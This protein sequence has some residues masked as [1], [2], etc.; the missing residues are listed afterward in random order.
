MSRLSKWLKPLNTPEPSD[1]GIGLGGN[2]GDSR[3]RIFEALDALRAR[4]VIDVTAVSSIYRTAPWGPVVQDD[5]ANA[6]AIGT[7]K[8]MPLALLDAIKQIERDLGRVETVR[9]G[10]RVIDID[11]LYYGDGAYEDAR[12]VLPHR[13]LFQRAFVL[14]PLAEIAPD[15]IIG[16]RRIIDAA[17]AI[18]S[19]DVRLWGNG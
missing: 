8:L 14:H 6:C 9:W 5:F 13:D 3:V 16:G 2:V 1:V 19:S 18:D 11:I 7:T 4:R 10:P 15:R 17:R 12:L